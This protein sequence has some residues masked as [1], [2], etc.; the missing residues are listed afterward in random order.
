MVLTRK[1]FVRRAK[2]I[3]SFRSPNVRS[4]LINASVKE[5]KRSN[6]RFDEDR[7]RQFIRGKK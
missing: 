3:K 1:D 5:F 2:L 6:P 7:F 4:K